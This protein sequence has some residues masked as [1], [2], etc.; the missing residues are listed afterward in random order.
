MAEYFE[1]TLYVPKRLITREIAKL[2][3]DYRKEFP[4]TEESEGDCIYYLNS[5][6]AMWGKFEDI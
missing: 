6:E 2:I 4:D 5:P 1:A 3:K